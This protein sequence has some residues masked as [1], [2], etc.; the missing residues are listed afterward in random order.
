MAYNPKV[1]EPKWHSYW[2]EN[3]TFRV[4]IDPTRRKFYALDMFPYLSGAGLHV[5]HPEGIVT[6]ISSG[7]GRRGGRD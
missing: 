2:H 5:G 4:E 1:L 7:G 3:Q 6:V